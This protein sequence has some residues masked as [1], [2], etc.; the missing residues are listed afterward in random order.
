MAYRFEKNANGESDLVISGF[1]KGIAESPLDGIGSIKNFNIRY[2]KGVAYV[3]YKRQPST[4]VLSGALLTATLT[5]GDTTATLKS[6][7]ATFPAGWTFKTGTYTVTFSS[8][9]TKV[10]TFTKGSN[11]ISWTGGLASNASATISINMT[12]SIASAKWATQSP[13]GIIYFVDSNSNVWK[14]SAVNSSTFSPVLGSTTAGVADSGIQFW[15]NYLLL[16]GGNSSGKIEICGDGTGDAGVTSANWNTTSTTPVTR[17][18]TMT[19]PVAPATDI[20]VSNPSGVEYIFT[21]TADHGFNNYDKVAFTLTAGGSLPTNIVQNRVYMVVLDTSKIFR[22]TNAGT[23]SPT[24]SGTLGSGN[25]T[26][27][28]ASI[29]TLVNHGLTVGQP[30]RLSTTGA[31]PTG[32]SA[33]TTYY[34]TGNYGSGNYAPN[35]TADTFMLTSTSPLAITTLNGKTASGT[36]SGTQTLIAQ[37]GVWPIVNTNIAIS[38]GIGGVPDKG[39]TTAVLDSYT[40]S[41]GN[42]YGVWN[43]PTGI[44]N[45]YI[46]QEFS[47]SQY[48][49]ANLTCGSNVITFTP[50]LNAKMTSAGAATC[51]LFYNGTVT[52]QTGV[53]HMCYVAG[54]DG[55]MYF[56]NGANI[57]A[58]RETDQQVFNKNDMNTFTFYSNILGLPTEETSVWISEIRNQLIVAGQKRIYP[59]D[60]SKPYWDSFVPMDEKIITVTNILNNLYIT[61]GNKGNIYQSNGYSIQRYMKLPDYIAGVTDPAWN[62]GGV[63]SHRQRLWMQATALNG[64]T[65]AVIS[66]GLFS[67]DLDSSVL[68]IEGQPS[69]GTAPAG[70]VADGF[71]ISDIDTTINY[72]KYYSFVSA[73]S[74]TMDFN[75]TTLWSGNEAI[76]ETDLIPIG[77]YA[78]SKTYGTIEFKL[79]QPLQT[80]DSITV[81]ARK[82]LTD[83]WTTL[84]TTAGSTLQLSDLYKNSVQK[85]QW[86]Q[87]QI[88]ATCNSA[89]T[90]SSFVPIR[91]IRLR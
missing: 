84:G 59:W 90:A 55:D 66:Q 48:V 61:A 28:I 76:I 80:G 56:T 57:G 34:V 83:S 11:A 38:D 33:G 49:A 41:T 82:S 12:G 2:R 43:G 26:G 50:A 51:P 37:T 79:D 1:E 52:S 13:A 7:S 64:Q 62:W 4:L 73:T 85:W 36:Q 91:E 40:D 68:A 53:Q 45:L 5:A 71:M 87:L 15:N 27:T 31:L 16:V 44:Y 89:S 77:T 18:F 60:F 81:K 22:I 86:I 69:G 9:E 6:T 88:L 46:A 17:T 21:T 35:I 24:L 32:W 39:A 8:A 23:V 14:Q 30:L 47:R 74:S 19:I 3:N 42:S 65:G 58:F 25:L 29:F 54:N 67:L 63:M 10:V 72:D 70:L 20:V 75:D 78:Q